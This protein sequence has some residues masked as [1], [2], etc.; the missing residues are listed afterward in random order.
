M[1]RPRGWLPHP[2]GDDSRSLGVAPGAAGGT[3]QSRGTPPGAVGR[4]GGTPAGAGRLVRAGE[5]AP[6]SLSASL[7]AP[8]EDV[9]AGRRA[10]RAQVSTN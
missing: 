9:A 6:G 10:S 7:L 8:G 2:G 5:R 1:L 4:P 3:A